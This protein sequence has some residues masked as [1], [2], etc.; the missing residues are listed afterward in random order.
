[1]GFIIASVVL[2]LKLIV[3]LVI[4]GVVVQYWQEIL[5]AC[6]W[7]FLATLSVLGL[8]GLL[9][10]GNWLRTEIGALPTL[11]CGLVIALIIQGVR[12]INLRTQTTD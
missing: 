1:M 9:Y 8:I 7:V 3:G 4:I 10:L 11:A 5:T 6:G 12:L 2:A